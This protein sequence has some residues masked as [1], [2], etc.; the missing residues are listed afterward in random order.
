MM[1]EDAQTYTSKQARNEPWLPLMQELVRSYQAFSRHSARHVKQLGL[2]PP[3]FDVIAT[4]GNTEGMNFK[5]LGQTTL[6]TKGTLTGIIDRLEAKGLVRRVSSGSDRRSTLI[7]LTPAGET[8]FE[9]VFPEHIR[10]L[11]L[12]FN[13]LD[14]EEQTQLRRLLRRLRD[15]F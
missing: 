13:R 10:Y 7:Q 8:L 1:Q 14:P 5:T 12:S 9:R 15:Q 6:I 3:Q 2:T 4:L 11:S